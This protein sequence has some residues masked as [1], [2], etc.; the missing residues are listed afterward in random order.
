MDPKYLNEMLTLCADKDFVFD[1]TEADLNKFDKIIDEV[2]PAARWVAIT[3]R[4]QG[5]QEVLRLRIRLVQTST[6]S[7][8]SES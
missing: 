5:G 7:A 8:M 3:L 4:N 2:E 6:E 1:A